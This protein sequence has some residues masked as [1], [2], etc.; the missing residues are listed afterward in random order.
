MT[1]RDVGYLTKKD[2]SQFYPVANWA[3]VDDKPDL[4][5]FAKTTDLTTAISQIPKTD[6]S[7]YVTKDDLSKVEDE[8]TTLKSP[9]GSTWF[10]SV[11]NDG[12]LSTSKL[13]TRDG[14]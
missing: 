12:N 8:I 6:L 9:D 10:L 1:N 14:N 3:Y 11:D 2:G 13:V 7:N 5:V 4:S